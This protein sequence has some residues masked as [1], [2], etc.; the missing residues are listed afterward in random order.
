MEARGWKL[1]K[2]HG[3]KYQTGMPDFYAKHLLHGYR[4]IETK[5]L[6]GKL[7]NSQ[8]RMFAELAAYGEKFYVLFDEVDYDKLFGPDNWRDFR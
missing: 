8:K 6:R 1:I 7:R 2:L 4:W 5:V 3:N